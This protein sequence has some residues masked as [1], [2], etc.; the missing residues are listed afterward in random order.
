MDVVVLDQ[1]EQF[2]IE[3]QANDFSKVTLAARHLAGLISQPFEVRFKNNPKAYS[4]LRYLP[5]SMHMH[6]LGRT[7]KVKVDW[8]KTD[9]WFALNILEDDV[10]GNYIQVLLLKEEFKDTITQKGDVLGMFSV[11]K[12]A[13]GN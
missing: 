12:K 4:A 11:W 3:Q 10:V 13:S 9:K 5:T 8:T 6:L 7:C 2:E 1:E